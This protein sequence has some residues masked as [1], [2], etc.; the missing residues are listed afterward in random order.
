MANITYYMV[1]GTNN[2]IQLGLPFSGRSVA[3]DNPTDSYVHILAAD[4]YVPP[5]TSGWVI[6]FPHTTIQANAK[7]EGP[8]GQNNVLTPGQTVALIFSD[9]PSAFIGGTTSA[10]QAAAAAPQTVS[11]QVMMVT[12][13]AAA[14]ASGTD[15]T[16]V[17]AVAGEHV[18]G[19]TLHVTAEGAFGNLPV[20]EVR[21][22]TTGADVGGQLALLNQGNAS[23]ST[24]PFLVAETS[25]LGA[26]LTQGVGHSVVIHNAD[27]VS[28]TIRGFI[29][30]QQY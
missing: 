3:V 14:R 19:F 24:G 9:Q 16:M 17:S 28:H 10:V 7:L 15:L 8:V 30:F 11:G 29:T 21:D 1:A 25:Y 12:G 4:F 26:R 2:S 20:L 6:P 5:H 13:F 22:G 18:Y 23:L 27:S